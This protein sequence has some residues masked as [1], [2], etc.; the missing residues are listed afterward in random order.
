NDPETTTEGFSEARKRAEL[1]ES[2]STENLLHFETLDVLL[3][4]LAPGRWRLL[5]S[6]RRQGAMRIRSLAK[7]LA[8]DYKNTY[9]DVKQL[10]QI[11]LIEKRADG[12]IEVPWDIVEA[13]LHL[14]A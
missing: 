4:T 8:R 12:R 13:R 3:K 2:F 5:K 1:E 11:G 9:T 10:L 7:T 14:A 6:L